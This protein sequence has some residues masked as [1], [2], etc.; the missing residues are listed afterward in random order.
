MSEQPTPH[1]G[2]RV[3]SEPQ[4]FLR[5]LGTYYAIIPEALLGAGNPSAI[6]VYGVLDRFAHEDTCFASYTILQERTGL[7]KSTVIRCLKWLEDE[8]WIKVVRQGTGR[9]AT[10]YILPFRST[11]F[12]PKKNTQGIQNEYPTI[13]RTIDKEKETTGVV[14]QK[15]KAPQKKPLTEEGIRKLV[16]DFKG[17]WTEAEVRERIEEALNHTASLKAIDMYLYVRGWLR[18]DA[19]RKGGNNGLAGSFEKPKVRPDNPFIEYS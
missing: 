11:S 10:D 3:T 7:G 9:H 4:K 5:D 1:P 12:V 15:K 13:E 14:S 17:R 6:A 16:A 2:G 18:R 8:G 19:G